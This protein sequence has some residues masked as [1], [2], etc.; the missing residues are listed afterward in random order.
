MYEYD[1]NKARR[2]AKVYSSVYACDR[3]DNVVLMFTPVCMSV[4]GIR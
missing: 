2:W 4:T 3:S 1:K